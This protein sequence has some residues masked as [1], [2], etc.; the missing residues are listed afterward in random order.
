MSE[1]PVS[2][3]TRENSE[4]EALLD[5][6]G[7][8]SELPAAQVMQPPIQQQNSYVGLGVQFV[9]A[10]TELIKKLQP[11]HITLAMQQQHERDMKR[12]DVEIQALKADENTQIREL[13]SH[14][15]QRSRLHRVFYAILTVVTGIAVVLIMRGEYERAYE[16]GKGVITVAGLLFGG[17]YWE[18]SQSTKQRK[19]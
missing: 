2:T 15:R 11:E 3:L 17:R 9:N 19:A 8:P 1:K 18:Q 5:D 10:E 16:W 14:E 7:P 13:E 6:A 12:I 4:L